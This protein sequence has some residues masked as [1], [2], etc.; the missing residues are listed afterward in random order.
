MVGEDPVSSREIAE[1]AGYPA[2]ARAAVGGSHSAAELG[3]CP[4]DAQIDQIGRIV[5]PRLYF[6]LGISGSV[7]HRAGMRN[8][9]RNLSGA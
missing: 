5:H 6:A 2:A 4:R 3:W 8:R 1:V 7:R 9:N